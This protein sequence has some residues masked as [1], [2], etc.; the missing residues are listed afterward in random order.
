MLTLAQ[1]EQ[2]QSDPRSRVRPPFQRSE[3]SCAS[4]G[5]LRSFARCC[6]SPCAGRQ[7]QADFGVRL[8]RVAGGASIE[9][10]LGGAQTPWR[11]RATRTNRGVAP[12]R[13]PASVALTDAHRTCSHRSVSTRAR[14]SRA[15]MGSPSS[16]S[17]WEIASMIRPCRGCAAPTSS[18]GSMGV[19][20]R[21]PWAASR[22]VSAPQGVPSNKASRDARGLE[23]CPLRSIAARAHS[24]A[25]CSPFGSRGPNNRPTISQRSAELAVEPEDVL[26]PGL[27]AP[28][29]SIPTMIRIVPPDDGRLRSAL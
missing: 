16:P 11:S 7:G 12:L 25:N 8:G 28:P 27:V 3:P 17:T 9:C 20:D 23:R 24:R 15:C 13:L 18:P 22:R 6:V 1:D 26:H 2:Q 14:T 10:G 19:Q 4:P 29:S 21:L 5:T